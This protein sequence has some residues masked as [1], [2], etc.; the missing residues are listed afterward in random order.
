MP[1]C[2]PRVHIDTRC[3]ACGGKNVHVFTAVPQENPDHAWMANEGDRVACGDCQR[4][5][6]IAVEWDDASVV[7]GSG[8]QAMGD[9]P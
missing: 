1:G 6:F 4:E 5:G 3:D 7:W 8:V 9:A 2:N